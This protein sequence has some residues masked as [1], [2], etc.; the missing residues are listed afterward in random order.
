[1]G[2]CRKEYKLLTKNFGDKRICVLL[3]TMQ[4]IQTEVEHGIKN[5]NTVG[6]DLGFDM[7]NGEVQW[8]LG[9]APDRSPER[10]ARQLDRVFTGKYDK[11]D[12]D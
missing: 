11:S 10:I 4:D 3:D 12:L 2:P 5:G 6:S 8:L 1:M 9:G 7:D